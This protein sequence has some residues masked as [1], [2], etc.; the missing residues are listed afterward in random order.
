MK[1]RSTSLGSCTTDD[2]RRVL[3]DNIRDLSLGAFFH[4]AT[5]K[6]AERL[7]VNRQ[8]WRKPLAWFHPDASRADA[9]QCEVTDEGGL[10]CVTVF[11][12]PA[13]GRQD[14]A[15]SCT[16]GQRRCIHAA[17]LLIRLQQLLD[18]PRA[19]TALARWQASLQEHVLPS[20][21]TQHFW[22]FVCHLELIRGE[23]GCPAILLG[24]PVA[25]PKD[26]ASEQP[27]HWVAAERAR[28]HL[29]PRDNAR[30]AQL[31]GTQRRVRSSGATQYAFEGQIGAHLLDALLQAGACRL[32]RTQQ[33]LRPG[34]DRSP[35]WQWQHD[36]GGCA[37]IDL[38]L[39]AEI[40]IFD[41]HG[42]RYLDETTGEL[43]IMTLPRVV[44]DMLTT[45]PPIPPSE[46]EEFIVRWPP[47]PALAR[48]PPPPVPPWIEDIRAPLRCVLVL[49]ASWDATQGEHWFYIQPWAEYGGYRRPLGADVFL[50]QLIT[51]CGGR[52][53]RL[54]RSTEDELRTLDSLSKGGFHPFADFTG[55]HVCRPLPAAGAL[56][57][58]THHRGGQATFSALH[59]ELERLGD[60]LWCLEY[61]PDLPFVILTA[62]P[63]LRASLDR[64]RQPGMTLFELAADVAGETIDMLPVILRGLASQAFALTRPANEPLDACWLAPLGTRRLVPLP[65]AQLRAWLAPLADLLERNLQTEGRHWELSRSQAMAL[66][67]SLTSEGVAVGGGLA[68]EMTDALAALRHALTTG[69]VV[70]PPRAFH[71][72]LRHYQLQGLQ[73]LQALS[74][75]GLGGV[76]ADDMG[77]GKTVQI[78]AHLVLEKDAGR[79]STPALIVAPTSLVFNWLDEIARF[80]P[81]LHCINLTGPG[82]AA[83][84]GHIGKAEVIITSYALLPMD[85]S[86]LSEQDYAMLVL[87][88]AQWI[89]NPSS[90]T[91]RAV[92]VLRAH[93]RVAVTGTPL[94]NHLGELWAHFDAV[95]PSYLGDARTFQRHFRTPIERQEDDQRRDIL[96]QR[97]APFLLRRD[98][99]SVAPELP[100]KIETVLRIAMAEPQ[101]RL[102]ESLRLAQSELVREALATYSEEQARIVVLSALLRLRQVCCHPALL[103]TS[104]GN[105]ESAKLDALLDLVQSLRD[106]GRHILIFSQF[107]SMLTLIAQALDKTG[108]PYATL[109]GDT[110]DRATPVRNFQAGGVP[111][112]LASLKAGGVGLNLTKADAIIHYDPWWNPAVER[113]A[114]DRAHR[115]GRDTP[116]LVFKLLCEDTIE[117]KVESMKDHKGDLARAV[118]DDIGKVA[119]LS[120][121]DVH[122]LLDLPAHPAQRKPRHAH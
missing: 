14:L 93:H 105:I 44:W 108:L 12:Y 79:L 101:R 110:A 11:L 88:E 28:A 66:T 107:T 80:A 104:H 19:M 45:M 90:Q 64:G 34:I 6:A 106:E 122:A 30:L 51:R 3:M 46:A 92:R 2:A 4:R 99:E 18:W 119:P 100:T 49:C 5:L 70:E 89:K 63:S 103:P 53:V 37:R 9:L 56:A 23:N 31:L 94:E 97:I 40:P 117:E 41:L 10:V 81:T 114:V 74:R 71:G 86:V 102:Y 68:M 121:R 83:L 87:D 61:H 78:I 48:L 112:L 38:D 84:F 115:I 120:A 76:L 85:I 111:I 73:W 62:P 27:I 42:L 65:L 69:A 32:S 113:Q 54:H 13:M 29:S 50:D 75:C 47:H 98:K 77:L 58:A 7:A 36:D 109:T 60:G 59:T 116:V 57:H 91:A 20:A 25:A 43:G 96:R 16:C 21:T 1:S 33:I 72:T 15:T 67:D 17:A 26:D 39:P 35:R 22:T 118:L 82:R 55:G 95:L 24:N 52:H 8:A